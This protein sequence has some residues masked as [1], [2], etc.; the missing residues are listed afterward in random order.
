M[1]TFHV[2]STPTQKILKHSRF[3]FNFGRGLWYYLTH[4]MHVSIDIY[5]ILR[6]GGLFSFTVWAIDN[7]GWIPDTRSSFQSL[8]FDA[9]LPDSVPMALHG[10]NEWIDV[11]GVEK[12]LRAIGFTDV[13]VQE[14]ETRTRVENADDFVST[15]K[16]ML[17]W[18]AGSSWEETSKAKAKELEGGI[19]AWIADHLNKKYGGEGWD[20]VWKSIIVTCVKP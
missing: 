12:E 4:C 18:M 17:D 8:P 16:G 10:K 1:N 20:T 13:K 14:L 6:P 9:P 5:R 2:C 19:D 7:Q 15:F 11:M 3:I